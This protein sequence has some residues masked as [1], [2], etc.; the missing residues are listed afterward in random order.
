MMQISEFKGYL[1]SQFAGTKFYSGAIDKSLT[2]C[3]GVYPK[4]T[5]SPNLALGGKQ[6][7]S[8][9]KLPFSILVHWTE[10]STQC[11]AK[12]NEIYDL[13]FG[14][15]NFMIGNRR[16][17]NIELSSP[18]PIDLSRDDNNICEMV[19]MGTIFYEKE[20]EA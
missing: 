11:E 13:L 3:I 18:C 2:Q 5:G 20:V 7:T 19:I 10:S 1:E 12:A 15:S 16:I 9:G 6:N 14:A 4:G 8:Y 17:I